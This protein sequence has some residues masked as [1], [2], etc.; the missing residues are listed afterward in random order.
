MKKE[1]LKKLLFL[2][3]FI[4]GT[5]MYS[6]EVSGTISDSNGPLAGANI[7]EKG[8][9][10]GAIADFDGNY[11]ITNL[12]PNAILVFSFVGYET[13]EVVVGNQTTINVTLSEDA[14][15]LDEVVVVGYGKTS[16]RLVTGAISSVK[17]E[18]ITQTPV[19]SADQALQGQA[20]GVTIINS[21]SP[22]TAPQVQIR[23]LGTFGN[24]TPLYVIDGIVSGGIN[25]INPNDIETIDV[26]KDASTA[27]IYGS[28]ASNGVVIITTK[29]GKAGK[30]KVT[31]DSY[32]SSQSVPRT[33]DL[34]NSSQF[35]D[36]VDATYGLPNRYTTDPAST[37]RDTDWQDEIFRNAI[38]HN[39][40]IGVSGGS[41]HAIFNISA[42][43]IDQEGIV[44][45]TGFNRASLRANS[46]FKIGDKFKIGETLAIADTEMMN[47][48]Q[49][50]GRTLIEH[51]IKSLPYTPVFDANNPGGFGGTDTTLDNG[52]DPENP[53]RVQ[54]ISNNIT[55]V[56]KI[57]GSL[58][59]SYEFTPGLEYK[60]QYGF[61]RTS[62]STNILRPS[63]DEGINERNAAQLDQIA[64]IFNSN[65]FTN[66]L[67]YSKVFNDVHNLDV[68]AVVEK[69]ETTARNN[70]S[71]ASNPLTDAVPVIQG[72]GQITNQLFEYGLIS[73]I[74]RLNYNYDNKYLISASIRRD[75]SSRFG[76][77]NR[78][79][80]FPAFSLGWV[81]SEEDF[82]KD[83]NAISSLKL[84][85]SWGVTGNDGSNDYV[86]EAGLIPTYGYIGL[87]NNVGVSNFGASNP[88]LKWEEAT[89]TNIG[90]DASLFNNA[91]NISLEYYNNDIADV[92]VP[93]PNVTSDGLGA[94]FTQ[95]NGA[96]TNT[97]GFE[98]N[99]GYNH[100]TSSDFSWSANL[101]LGTS[102]NKATDLG[103][104]S[105]IESSTFEG[106]NLSRIEEGE[107]LFFFYGL[108]TDGLFQQG[109]DTSAQPNAAPGDIRFVDQNNDGIIN[110][111]DNVKIGNPFPKL[112][113]GL[114]LSANYKNFDATLFFSGVSGND[115]YNTNIYD[116]EGMT[117]LFN[118]G[119]AVLDRWTPTNTN[120]TVP[121]FT[122]DHS[123]NVNRSD[124]FIEDGSYAKLRNLTIGYSLPETVLS[125][126]AKGSISKFRIYL[127]AQ[128]LFTITNY[129]GYDPEIGGSTT[130]TPGQQ[131][132]AAGV[133]IDRGVY[134]QPRSFIAGVQ[135]SF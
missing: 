119:T 78:W 46:E 71:Q 112:T 59:A 40:N 87:N 93:I 61:E 92:I 85:G 125:T 95:R 128:N 7:L 123:D 98:F 37:Q 68:L 52:S 20:P 2:I 47:E 50:G 72:N 35:R 26:L 82:L 122:A 103:D 23:G 114:N 104:L 54:T 16:R 28:R 135:L 70:R 97:R 81:L 129:S 62:S 21:G 17:S 90:L 15:V 83:S 121:R 79:G 38:L 110:S 60:F 111:A 49:A 1:L 58:Y 11:T 67:S 134:P 12:S 115:I 53:V 33:L 45:N 99:I 131:S 77:N 96:S 89:M 106:E 6:Q 44:I 113:Y 43:Y 101:N 84:R 29:R 124:R 48:E 25:E 75:G 127:A 88:D 42:G 56:S 64:N 24:N 13:K 100:N 51:V 69:F 132:P 55:D 22:G 63:F 105:F 8:T 118:A 107:S 73:Y 39:T 94:A 9:T 5:S 126:F 18:D 91:V 65:T 116:L 117:R 27:A 108:E 80:T 102:K 130:V 10:N 36:F 4:T 19:I 41:E 32:L 31:L 66:S 133:G 120:T 76:K 14:S 30:T 34:L 74:G 3:V 109:D 57:L 86:F